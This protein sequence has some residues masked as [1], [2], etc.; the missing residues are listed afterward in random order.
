MDG[1]ARATVRCV[2]RV[3][4]VWLT[5]QGGA[6]EHDRFQRMVNSSHVTIEIREN[7]VEPLLYSVRKG[8]LTSGVTRIQG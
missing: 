7:C 3:S 4:L 8:P 5:D 1:R 2:S 6:E